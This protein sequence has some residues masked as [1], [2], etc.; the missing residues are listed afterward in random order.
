MKLTAFIDGRGIDGLGIFYRC[1]RLGARKHTPHGN[2][3]NL[4]LEQ[5][6]W[7]GEYEP[8]SIPAS[9]SSFHPP[10]VLISNPTFP[11]SSQPTAS[12]HYH[13]PTPPSS[14][15]GSQIGMS[16]VQAAYDQLV[17]SV[18]FELA[19]RGIS[20]ERFK[21]ALQRSLYPMASTLITNLPEF[22]HLPAVFHFLQEKQLCHATDV[23]LLLYILHEALQER[24]LYEMVLAYWRQIEHLPIACQQFQFKQATLL[25]TD[26]LFM[27]T[28]HPS[29]TITV[30]DVRRMKE[31]LAEAFHLPRHLFWF[32]GY[33]PGSIVLTWQ[34]FASYHDKLQCFLEDSS[35]MAACEPSIASV[36]IQNGSEILRK[37]VSSILPTPTSLSTEDDETLVSSSSSFSFPKHSP[38]SPVPVV[39]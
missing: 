7:L 5:W 37:D 11:P 29:H 20:L 4:L 38:H 25:S 1:L 9:A 10:Q 33:Q 3:A 14:P 23:D 19:T 27:M 39:G 31:F 26:F 24:D 6:P 34:F 13:P 8:P 2:L 15:H 32:S 22:P 12:F 16:H 36:C 21:A 28:T 30:Q 17:R 18:C 35:K